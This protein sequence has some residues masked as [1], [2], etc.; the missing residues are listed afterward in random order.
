MKQILVNCR[1]RIDRDQIIQINRTLP[2]AIGHINVKIGDEVAPDYV[3]AEGKRPA[4]FRTVNLSD[5]LKINPKEGLKYLKRAMGLNIFKDELLAE[6]KGI[7]GMG[8]KILLSPADGI[9]DYYDEDSGRLKIKLFPKTVKLACGVWG[10]VENVD[11]SKG[12]ITIRTMVSLIYGVIGSG[13]TREGTLNVIGSKDVLVGSRQLEETMRGQIIV[14][15]EIVFADGLEKAIEFGI[16]GLIS[17]GINAKDYK[18]MAGGWNIYKKQWSDVGLSLLITEGFGSVHMGNDI[19]SLLQQSHGK[20]S[21]VDGN[22]NKLI[23]PSDDGGCMIYIRKTNLPKKIFVE[24]EPEIKPIE[25]QIGQK[26]RIISQ[27]CLGLEGVIE[28]VDK[29]QSKLPSGANT[30]LVTIGSKSRKI[31]VAH[32][33]LEVII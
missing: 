32:Q 18:S 27:D 9:L 7:M 14:G 28:E 17:G 11:E 31:R 4:G 3:L 15:G 19:F 10:I 6:K 29:T 2:S 20:F 22:R 24:T 16:A 21:I 23:L 30:T 8:N 1:T 25:L 13:K 5:E 12:V 26:V 33:N